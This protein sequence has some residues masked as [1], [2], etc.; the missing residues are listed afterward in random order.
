MNIAFFVRHF[1]ERGTE[2]SVYNYARYNEEILGNKSYIICFTERKQKEINFPATRV[3]YETFRSRFPVIEIGDIREMKK[4][5]EEREIEYFYTQTHGA[6]NDIYQFENAHIWN[7]CKTIKHCVFDTTAPEGDFHIS[8]SETL[9][10][11]Y[12][13]NIPV[14]PYIVESLPDCNADFRG[15]LKIP[16][17]AVVL[18]R[19]GGEDQFDIPFVHEAIIEYLSGETDMYFLF[20][21][22]NEFYQHPRIIYLDKN[23][24]LL[25]K[26]KFIDTCDAMIHARAMGETF[27]LAVAEF[28]IRNKPIITC[29][30]GDLE[31]FEILGDKA[32]VY[33][34]KEEL[35]DI[36]E[37]IKT[38]K[39][40]RNDWNAYKFYNPKNV[41]ELFNR[42]VFSNNGC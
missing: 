9:N 10:A 15:E 34:T 1:S 14:V 13:T 36:F 35:L 24:D 31:H 39:K 22:T 3:S 23:I 5:I 18:G 32:V 4:V 29:P 37:N 6:G 40:S 11:K 28:S 42:A 21:N 7:N 27:G 17:D 12:D 41:M 30:C 38:I 25:F 26:A 19:H 33:K 8:I 20:L 2:V 16:S